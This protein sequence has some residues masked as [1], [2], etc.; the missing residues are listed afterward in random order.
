MHLAYVLSLAEWT[1]ASL[2]HQELVVVRMEELI[3]R[4]VKLKRIHLPSGKT[5]IERC[6]YQGGRCGSSESALVR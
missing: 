5:D 2:Q 6:Q 4:E 1:A 3:Q